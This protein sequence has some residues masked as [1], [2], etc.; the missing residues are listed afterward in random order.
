MLRQS[1]IVSQCTQCQTHL[2]SHPNQ[3]MVSKPKPSTPFQE[4]AADFVTMLANATLCSWTALRTLFHW[5][6]KLLQQISLRQH[7]SCLVAQQFQIPF[8]QMGDPYSLPND[9]RTSL[10]RGFK[11]QISSPHCPQS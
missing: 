3:P 5:E 11:H 8:G 9:F 2:P 7:R 10:H 4:I 6:A 1:H